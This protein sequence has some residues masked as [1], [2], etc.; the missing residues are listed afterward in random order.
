MLALSAK[1]QKVCDLMVRGLSN[2][3]IA[4]TIGISV[5]TVETHRGAI[6]EKTGVRNVVELTRKMLGV[7]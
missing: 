1:Q 2:K 7:A 4:Q 6:L 5:R 3:E